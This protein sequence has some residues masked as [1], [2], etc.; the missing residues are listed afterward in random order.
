[1]CTVKLFH[2]GELQPT[3]ICALQDRDP[4]TGMAASTN[5]RSSAMVLLLN[6]P[7]GYDVACSFLVIQIF[8][9]TIIN[10]FDFEQPH[11]EV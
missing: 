7:W 6:N 11:V 9:C 5:R 1:M 3:A 4:R 10:C 8:S 2:M